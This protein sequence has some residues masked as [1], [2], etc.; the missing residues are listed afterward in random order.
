MSAGA[1]DHD[2]AHAPDVEIVDLG[3]PSQRVRIERLMAA[4]EAADGHVPF[5]DHELL[6]IQTGPVED[7]VGFGIRRD[8]ALAGYAHLSRLG[9][10]W[11][12]EVA[13]DPAWRRRGL[14]SMLLDAIVAHAAAHGGGTLSTWSSHDAPGVVGLGRRGGFRPSRTLL[15]MRLDALPERAPAMPDGVRIER[16]RPGADDAE[17]LALNAR[18]FAALPDQGAWT[19]RDLQTRLRAPWFDAGDFLV[20]RRGDAMAGACWTKLDPGA[21]TTGGRQLG[22]IYVVAVDPA[23][24]GSGLGRTLTLAGLAHLRSRGADVGMLYVD[25]ANEAAVRLYGDLGFRVHHQDVCLITD[26]PA[27]G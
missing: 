20:A 15:Q 4:C 16:F 5:G 21:R 23:E 27:A 19:A 7:H 17:W 22:E 1:H 24:R 13:V 10:A 26:V 6:A 9:D 12:C 8:D 18:A 11:F 2:A 14:A 25:H 3:D